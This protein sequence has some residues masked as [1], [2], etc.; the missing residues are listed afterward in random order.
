VL[1]VGGGR[2]LPNGKVVAPSVK[3]GDTVI[4]SKYGGSDV[5]VDGK[6]L[7]IVGESEILAVL[8]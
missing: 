5:K 2:I 7:K 8:G 1:A 3:V 6:E 4:Y